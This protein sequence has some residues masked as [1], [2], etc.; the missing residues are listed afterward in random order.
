M[1][2]FENILTSINGKIMTITINRPSNLNAL[3]GQTIAELGTAL[4]QAKNNNEIA[5]IIITGAGEKAFVAGADISEIANLNEVNGRSFA[6]SGQKVFEDIQNCEKPVIAAVNGFALGGGC[7]LAMACHIRIAVSSAKFGQ[8]EVSLGLIPGYGGT[9][10]LTSLVGRGKALELMMTGDLINAEEAYRIGLVNHVV[11]DKEELNTKVESMMNKI[12][13]KAPLAVGLVISCVNAAQGA[14]NG[15]Q[16][17]AN[18]FA[19]CCQ[20]NDKKEGTSSF[21]EKRA[22]QFKGN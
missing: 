21:L 4:E 6:E 1:T 16:I 18:G 9:Q 8:P 3:N 20:T 2:S 10:R 14:E 7:E 15:Y 12:I 19:H 17:E 5:G 11:S 22:P 13:A